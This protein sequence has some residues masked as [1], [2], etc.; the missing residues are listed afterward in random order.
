[1]KY[2][3]FWLKG[4]TEKFATKGSAKGLHCYGTWR[5]L[6]QIL[7]GPILSGHLQALLTAVLLLSLPSHQPPAFVSHCEVHRVAILHQLDCTAT[8]LCLQHEVA[9]HSRPS[10]LASQIHTNRHIHSKL[11]SLNRNPAFEPLLLKDDK[12]MNS[13]LSGKI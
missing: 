10:H 12:V 8:A 1:M 2:L 13:P 5:K 9:A 4:N 7:G 3:R 11:I 6:Q